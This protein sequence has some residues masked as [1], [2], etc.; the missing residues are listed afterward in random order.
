MTPFSSLFKRAAATLRDRVGLSGAGRG[1]LIH[2]L[3]IGTFGVFLPWMRGIDFLDPVML[4]AYACL[5]VLFAAPAGAQAFA[6]DR[7]QSLADALARIAVA[8]LYGEV[9]AIAMLMAALA[10]VHL[11]HLYFPIAP[12]LLGL[13]EASAFGVSASIAMAAIAGW[14]TA[15]LSAGAA[16][17]MI[18]V[19]FLGALVV[20]FFRSRWLPDMVTT[21]AVVALVVAA[22]AILALRSELRIPERTP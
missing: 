1:V 4:D 3:V 11:T 10:T 19:I 21:G 9:M 13:I 16:R 17:M 6:A 20:F 14:I 15:R 8:V 18:R 22:I 7:P 12:D 5:G 2:L